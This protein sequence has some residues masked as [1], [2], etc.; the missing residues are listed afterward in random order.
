[1]D[2]D[3]EADHQPGEEE[4]PRAD[5]SEKVRQCIVDSVPDRS[6]GVQGDKTEEPHERQHRHQ[7][8]DDVDRARSGR[9][10]PQKPCTQGHR[11][12]DGDEPRPAEGGFD[13]IA[14]AAEYQARVTQDR[15]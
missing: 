13:P 6:A 1:M 12:D 4:P 5:A 11:G 3:D 7:P 2:R 14:N 15:Q 10:R 9:L 8:R